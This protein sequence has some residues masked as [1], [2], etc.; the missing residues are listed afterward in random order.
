MLL[1]DFDIKASLRHI[2]SNYYEKKKIKK[3]TKINRAL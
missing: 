2:N 1:L 3:I